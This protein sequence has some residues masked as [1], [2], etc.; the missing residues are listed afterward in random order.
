MLFF[1]VYIKRVLFFRYLICD[2]LKY[3]IIINLNQLK[4]A[5]TA[6]LIFSI[7]SGN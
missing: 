4:Q 6:F 5:I 1:E 7:T 2:T 3:Q